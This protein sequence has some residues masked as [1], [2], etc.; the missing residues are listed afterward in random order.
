M[1]QKDIKVLVARL[2]LRTGPTP[3]RSRFEGPSIY[4]YQE[5]NDN[6]YDLV[7]IVTF[8][9]GYAWTEVEADMFYWIETV[10]P[11]EVIPA[12][13]PWNRS[14][15]EAIVMGLESLIKVKPSI[16]ASVALEKAREELAREQA[17]L[18]RH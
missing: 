13:H 15:P 16:K 18:G 12:P 17:A 3:S 5:G 9:G 8:P 6:R 4:I 1:F 11:G 10:W 14:L 7:S 2:G